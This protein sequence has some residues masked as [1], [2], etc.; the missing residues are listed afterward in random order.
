MARPLRI[1]Y[2]GAL[3]H[4]TARGNERKPLYREEYDYQKFLDILSALSQRFG[5]IIHGYVLMGNHYHLLIETPR[6]NITKAIHYLNATYSGYFNRKY[7]RAGHLFQGRYKG[8]LIEKERYLLTVSRYLH[9]N[10]V[11]AGLVKKPE[12]YRWSSYPAYTG[13]VRREKWLTYEWILGQYSGDIE[14]AR[15]MY[16]VFIEEGLTL[17]KNPFEQMKAGLIVGSEGFVEEIKKKLKL[18]R[19]REIPDSREFTRS[20]SYEEVMALVAKRFGM[21]VQELL[22]SGKRNNLSRR[23]CLYLLRNK[24]DMSNEEIARDFGIG[25]TAVSQAASRLRR[26]MMKDKTLRKTIQEIERE[27]GEE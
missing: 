6:G 26:D 17:N 18:K 13:R 22:K 9:L 8:L 14:K 5:V 23:I 7:N 20:I 25:Y 2:E 15:R 11:R 1:E 21:S 24:T 10:P 3:Y 12:E 16:K 27:L 4:V 19:I